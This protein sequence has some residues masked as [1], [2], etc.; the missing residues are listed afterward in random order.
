MIW[1]YLSSFWDLLVAVNVAEVVYP[2]LWFQQIGNAVAG[3]LGKFFDVIF[4][5]INDL[6][7][8]ISWLFASLKTIFGALLS[9]INYI[10]T[11]IRFFFATAFGTPAD[12]IAT[13]TFSPE[14]LAVFNAVPN[15]AVIS[16]IIGA[17]IVLIAGISIFRLILRS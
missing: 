16:G 13:Y 14:I 11:I 6:F 12:P 17:L 10:I 4:H 8:F 9:P 2:I 3:A 15:W 1:D 5:N 7:V